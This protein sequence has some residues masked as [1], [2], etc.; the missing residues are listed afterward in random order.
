[1]DLF[2]NYFYE[3]GT[4]KPGTDI[5]YAKDKLTTENVILV[6]LL[7][8]LWVALIV[9]LLQYSWNASISRV[10]GTEDITYVGSLGLLIVALILIPRK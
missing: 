2:Q 8:V 6:L 1:M 7:A 10:F 5:K 3:A 4:H 9:W